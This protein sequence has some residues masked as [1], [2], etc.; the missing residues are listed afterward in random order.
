MKLL[1]LLIQ[2]VETIEHLEFQGGK[3]DHVGI[4]FKKSIRDNIMNGRYSLCRTYKFKTS[5]TSPVST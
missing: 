5:S 1:K 4:C 2:D 3:S